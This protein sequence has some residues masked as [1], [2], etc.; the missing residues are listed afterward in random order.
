[1]RLAGV[2]LPPAGPVRDAAL[3]FLKRL[4]VGESV[5]FQLVSPGDDHHPPRGL[6]FREPDGLC[7]NL[8]LVRLGYVKARLF[9]ELPGRE[10]FAYYQRLARRTGKGIWAVRTQA[11]SRPTRSKTVRVPIDAPRARVPEKDPIVYVTRTGHKYHRAGCPHLRKSRVAKRLSEVAG[12][13]EPCKR[14]KPPV[15][16]DDR[17]AP[18]SQP[19]K[20]RTP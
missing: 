4:L 15:P 1:M 17:A 8:E 20:R 7:V 18:A 9:K 2:T 10:A 6:L 3:G 13:Y 19:H 14:C 16:D 5:R 11:A 12:R